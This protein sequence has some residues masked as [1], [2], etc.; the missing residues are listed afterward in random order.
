MNLFDEPP[1]LSSFIEEHGGYWDGEC[2]SQPLEDWRYEVN[3]NDT[4]LSYWEWAYGRQT[5]TG[6]RNGIS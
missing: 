1:T 6:E 2:P 4:R 3:N 5:E